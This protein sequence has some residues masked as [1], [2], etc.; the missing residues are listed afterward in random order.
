M[1]LWRYRVLFIVCTH[2]FAHCATIT[3]KKKRRKAKKV[4]IL[5]WLFQRFQGQKTSE[6]QKGSKDFLHLSSHVVMLTPSPLPRIFKQPFRA[7]F[8][9]S[10]RFLRFSKPF[11][12]AISLHVHAHFRFLSSFA[13]ITCRDYM[14]PASFWFC[15]CKREREKG[16][17]R[18]VSL[19]ST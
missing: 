18:K 10:S 8:H 7:L 12:E 17:Q 4:K 16:K 6:C 1:S 9:H 15:L 13:G 3:R 19:I 2:L 5:R 14:F 11:L